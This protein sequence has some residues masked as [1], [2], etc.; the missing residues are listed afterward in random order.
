MP[1]FLGVSVLIGASEG[2]WAELSSFPSAQIPHVSSRACVR[3]CVPAC[4]CACVTWRDNASPKPPGTPPTFDRV[5]TECPTTCMCPIPF[6]ST[7]AQQIQSN[8]S[9]HHHRRQSVASSRNC[10]FCPL[11]NECAKE[12]DEADRHGTHA[13]VIIVSKVS[14]R[15]RTNVGK[16]QLTLGFCSAAVGD[17]QRA[18]AGYVLQTSYKQSSRRHCLKIQNTELTR[19][20]PL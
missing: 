11:S 20:M 3:A 5:W 12:T 17:S 18:Q 10:L 9:R 19:L 16:A 1:I 6:D 4:V 15:T 7:A 8:L 13:C 2:L 14:A